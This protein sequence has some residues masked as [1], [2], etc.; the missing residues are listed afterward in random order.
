MLPINSYHNPSYDNLNDC[1]HVIVSAW[2]MHW[3]IKFCGGH[4]RLG[5]AS[6]EAVTP[7]WATYMPSDQDLGQLAMRVQGLQSELT[8]AIQ[9]PSNNILFKCLTQEF[10]DLSSTKM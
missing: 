10:K 8:A 6:E 5:D 3:H 7:S 9:K 2:G 4:T 1:D